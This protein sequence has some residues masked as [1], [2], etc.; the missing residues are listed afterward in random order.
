MVEKRV[1]L[2]VSK[3]LHSFLK[4]NSIWGQTLEETIWRLLG[5]KELTK[6]QKQEVKAGYEQSL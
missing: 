2:K 1:T 5:Q 6:E 3:K 4:K